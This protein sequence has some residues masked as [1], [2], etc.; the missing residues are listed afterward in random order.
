VQGLTAVA[1]DLGSTA[2]KAGLLTRDG[3]L[4]GIVSRPAP[5][6]SGEGGRY[7]SAALAYAETADA[8][9]AQCLAQTIERPPLGLCSQRSSFLLWERQSGK[10]VT[11]LIS[12]QDERGAAACAELRGQETQIRALTGLS[13]TPY[14]F[15]PKLRV[16]LQQNPKWRARLLSGEW[17]V[18]M[19][20]TFMIWRWTH[21]AQYVTDASMAARTLLLDVGRAQW[22]PRLCELF[23]VPLQSL[24]QVL[25]SVGLDLRLDNGL[26]LQAS[27]G[28]QSAAL[29]ASLE[30]GRPQVMVNLGTGG[31]VA[32][33]LP[34]G[35]AVLPGY[36]RTLVWQNGVGRP[37]FACEGTL[38]SI[39]VALAGYPAAACDPANLGGDD[40]F[41]LA[42]PSGM[43][44]PYFRSDLGVHFSVPAAH[45]PA[46]H[47]ALLLQEAIIFRV[48]RMLEEMQRTFGVERA[49]LA[50]GLSHLPCLQQGIAR[51]APCAI[52]CLRQPEA[53][54]LGAAQLA[55][56]GCRPERQQAVL[57]D[58]G[59]VGEGLV[60]KFGHWKHWLDRLLGDGRGGGAIS[61]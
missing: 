19:L 33:P 10:P 47:I 36:L 44:A 9:L 13:L 56:G 38:N 52:Y 58:A 27:L 40:I 45:L 41:C 49:Y 28:D 24:P 1:L 18:G 30:T 57:V 39:G 21:G 20:D 8:V 2:I 7:E 22:S 3:T 50:G 32:C 53:G 29:L 43:G 12:W 42:E 35:P 46:V 59:A 16:L 54:L 55:A 11:P 37:H 34:E 60:R 51:C 6:V 5:P 31:F 26:V 23:E 61:V 25:P 48:A 15:A 4:T 17:L 14:Y